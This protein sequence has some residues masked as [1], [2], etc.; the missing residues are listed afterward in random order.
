MCLLVR[1]NY[2]TEYIPPSGQF[3]SDSATLCEVQVIL[4]ANYLTEITHI[5]Y[6]HTALDAPELI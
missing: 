3:H 5:Y 6:G 4:K 1:F 2:K